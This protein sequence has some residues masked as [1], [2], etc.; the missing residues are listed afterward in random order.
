MYKLN[1]FLP[2]RTQPFLITFFMAVLAFKRIVKLMKIRKGFRK[3]QQKKRRRSSLFQ[4]MVRRSA[5]SAEEARVGKSVLQISHSALPFLEV[6]LAN[7]QVQAA[8]SSVDQPDSASP[9][10]QANEVLIRLVEQKVAENRKR[11][12][13]PSAVEVLKEKLHRL[14][15]LEDHSSSSRRKPSAAHIQGRGTHRLTSKKT[16]GT[17]SLIHSALLHSSEQHADL[18][19]ND[20]FRNFAHAMLAEDGE[21]GTSSSSMVD[22]IPGTAIYYGA[23]I[24][25]QA[26]HGGF[27]SCSTSTIKCSAHKV[28]PSC[29][30]TIKKSEDLTDSGVVSYGDALWLQFGANFVFGAKY[31]TLQEGSSEGG[32]RSLKP[33]LVSCK[34]QSMFKAQQYGRWIILKRG[35]PMGKGRASNV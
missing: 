7:T 19:Q 35:D 22:Y 10:H 34:R 24:S 25:L 26:R 32:A 23:S 3:P 28:L 12:A 27:L 11:M 17:H 21:E 5:E 1:Y 18:V 29:K 20:Y 16:P 31:G 15:T 33:S 9:V 4:N 14:A 2:N 8:P 13:K 6:S 30:L